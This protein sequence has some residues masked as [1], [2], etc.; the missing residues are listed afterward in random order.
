MLGNKVVKVLEISIINNQFE[1]ISI[2]INANTTIG[3]RKVIFGS[4][5]IQKYI[6]KEDFEI[7]KVKYKW[8][9]RSQIAKWIKLKGKIIKP[10]KIKIKYSS[11][12]S[13]NL[14]EP[15]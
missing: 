8:L 4:N 10:N 1:F 13:N 12:H 14:F 7:N 3:K 6:S 9:H 15:T 11:K 5:D 2:E